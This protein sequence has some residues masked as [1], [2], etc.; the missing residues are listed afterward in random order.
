MLAEATAQQM[1][2][3]VDPLTAEAE[4]FSAVKHQQLSGKITRFFPPSGGCTPEVCLNIE[5]IMG[6]RCF[7]GIKPYN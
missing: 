1:A 6:Y 7:F 5:K 3:G 2:A 4:L